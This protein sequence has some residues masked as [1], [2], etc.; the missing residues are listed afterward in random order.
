MIQE[1]S[2]E[3]VLDERERIM[4]RLSHFPSTSSFLLSQNRAELD[5]SLQQIRRDPLKDN[6][7]YQLLIPG[8]EAQSQPGRSVPAQMSSNVS[9][10][11]QVIWEEREAMSNQISPSSGFKHFHR[12]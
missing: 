11:N 5:I 1:L 3:R 10:I 4:G 6:D 2:I 9:L 8:G 12:R 7:D